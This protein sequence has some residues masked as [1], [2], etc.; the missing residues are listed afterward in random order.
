MVN[1]IALVRLSC[2]GMR[3]YDIDAVRIDARG[4]L[5]VAVA[6]SLCVACELVDIVNS[7]EMG[8]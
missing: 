1:R 3:S 2:G 5:Y 6:L 4:R 7:E 8:K